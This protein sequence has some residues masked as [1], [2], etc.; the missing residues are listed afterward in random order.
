MDKER[1]MRRKKKK[2]TKNPREQKVT[3]QVER[4]KKERRIGGR[5]EGERE[6]THRQGLR[7][8]EIAM[9]GPKF[10][11]MS[12]SCLPTSFETKPLPPRDGVGSLFPRGIGSG[13]RAGG[14]F[15]RLLLLL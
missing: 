7:R 14:V 2:E 10:L 11:I 5:R 1:E 3:K 15:D 13:G 9:S 8:I 4:G 6:D 12:S